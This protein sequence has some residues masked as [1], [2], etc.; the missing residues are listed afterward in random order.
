M[1]KY[2]QAHSA[3]GDSTRS[4]GEGLGEQLWPP[5]CLVAQLCPTLCDPTHCS[6]SGSVCGDSP[7][8]NS[9]V[10]CH[11]LLQ[12]IFLTQGSNPGLPH[13]RWVLYQLNYLGSL[14][15]ALFYTNGPFLPETTVLGIQPIVLGAPTPGLIRIA[16]QRSSSPVSRETAWWFEWPV[17]LNW[18]NF[19]DIWQ[20][21][22]TFT[23]CHDGGR[24]DRQEYRFP[25]AVL[26]NAHKFSSFSSVQSLSCVRFFV[27]P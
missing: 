16:E 18:G 5:L 21:L 2:A 25:I 14:T 22:G 7:G 1:H 27:T 20:C 26:T 24:S 11:A 4:L 3:T 9:G 17:F 8:K 19:G 23:G 12:G 15:P 10:G 13:R 6:P